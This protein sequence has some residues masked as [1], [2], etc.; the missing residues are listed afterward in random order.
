[1]QSSKRNIEK[2]E[3]TPSTTFPPILGQA[4]YFQKAII[5][6]ATDETAEVRNLVWTLLCLLFAWLPP[7]NF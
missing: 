4:W 5:F 7:L 2:K 1:M 3:P 6:T